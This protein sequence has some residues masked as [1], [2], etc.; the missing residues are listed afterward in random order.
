MRMTNPWLDIPFAD[1]SGHMGLPEVGQTRF[2][3]GVFAAA[4]REVRPRS[5]LH[6]GC[7]AGNGLEHVDP[8]V[9]ER[10]LGIDVN[11]RF[12][13]E[14]HQRFPRPRFR[15]ETRCG[16]VAGVVLPV[17]EFALVQAALVFEYLDWRA[18]LPRLAAALGPGGVLSAVL[19]MPCASLP[20]VTPSP[21]ASLARL[22]AI[23]AFV[24]PDEVAARAAFVGLGV[25]R[26]RVERL[27]SGK[28]FAVM[29]F[30]S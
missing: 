4:L 8:A 10:V 2:L 17:G 27:P 12:L 24:D 6:V 1:Y 23:F 13:A 20:A 9:T 28:E 3:N 26:R 29:G 15:L 18:L 19:Q 21:F 5:V 16:D 30:T 14:L 22:E 7:A 25:C 11:P